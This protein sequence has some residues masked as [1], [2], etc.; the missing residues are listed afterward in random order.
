M[1]LPPV[2]EKEM[3]GEKVEEGDDTDK[4]R[5]WTKLRCW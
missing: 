4:T 5:F 3:T 1:A 2:V